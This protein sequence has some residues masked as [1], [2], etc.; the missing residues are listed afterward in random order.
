MGTSSKAWM[1]SS[2]STAPALD[3]SLPEKT[4]PQFRSTKCTE[5][6][7]FI[8][9]PC[10]KMILFNFLMSFKAFL[11]LRC[12]CAGS[13]LQTCWSRRRAVGTNPCSPPSSR[14]ARLLWTRTRS[15]RRPP[16]HRPQS[17]CLGEEEEGAERGGSSHVTEQQRQQNCKENAEQAG[18][19]TLTFLCLPSADAEGITH[20]PASP[21]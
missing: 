16:S 9:T 4:P 11:T 1:K 3:P 7:F 15:G 5:F 2:S 12:R 18:R 8:E 6:G 17:F 14:T 20:I 10:V 19:R 21:T 13:H